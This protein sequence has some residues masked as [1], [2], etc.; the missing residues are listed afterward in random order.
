MDGFAVRSADLAGAP[1]ELPVVGSMNAGS[2]PGQPLNAGEVMRIMTGAPM[3][4]GADAV[5]IREEVDDSGGSARFAAPV[6]PGENIRRAG[7]D[8]A[9]GSQA[10]PDGILIGAGEIGMLAALGFARVPVGR[11]P[12][13]AVLCTGDELCPLGQEPAPGQIFSSNEHALAAQVAE[14]G[15]E[16]VRAEMVPDDRGRTES[17][18]AAALDCDAL[19]TSG[20]V[21]VGD[22][23]HVREALAAAGVTIDFWKIAM[24]PGKPVVF[25]VA[26]SGALCFGLPGNPVSSLVSFELFVRPALLA[27]QGAARIQRPRAQVTLTGPAHKH[28]GRAH[29]LRASLHRSG[30][31][32]EAEPY[33]K[34]GSSMMS[35][36]VGIDALVELAADLGDVPAGTRCPALLLRAV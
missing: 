27:M 15:G 35:S 14:A 10:L 18:I 33:T 11:R 29:Y 30:D 8:V 6:R 32:I 2:R 12:R 4:D 26:R 21:S 22:R 36:I 1:V 7:E 24:R 20:G 13:V 5:V 28:P 25:G 3:P 9:P 17:A 16:V 31:V 23:D 19:V 34:Q